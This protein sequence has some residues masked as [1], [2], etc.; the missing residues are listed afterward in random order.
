[1]VMPACAW[2]MTVLGLL[3]A[4]GSAFSKDFIGERAVAGWRGP[5]WAFTSPGSFSTRTRDI[6]NY[7]ALVLETGAGSKGNWLDGRWH[8]RS[9]VHR[10]G[11]P[12][13]PHVPG[14]AA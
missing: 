3:T 5:A 14:R 13:D 11:R 9:A 6:W 12:H 7:R 8:E 10:R 1:R 2:M 4:I